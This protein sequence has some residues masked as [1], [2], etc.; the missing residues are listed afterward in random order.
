MP[1]NRQDRATLD[2][3]LRLFPEEFV[4]ARPELMLVR[5]VSLQ[6]SWQLGAFATELRQTLRLLDEPLAGSPGSTSTRCA[7]V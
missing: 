4:R 1:S 3:W 5:C 2:R 6:L 7:D